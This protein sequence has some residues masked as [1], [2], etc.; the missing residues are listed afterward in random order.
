MEGTNKRPHRFR[1]C[2]PIGFEPDLSPQFICVYVRSLLLTVRL[3]AL[4][5]YRP[6]EKVEQNAIVS[7]LLDIEVILQ[8]PC[9]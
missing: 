9:W 1:D 8:M 5:L 3:S 6:S 4:Y 2:S 7:D